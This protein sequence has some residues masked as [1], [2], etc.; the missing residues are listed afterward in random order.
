[1]SAANTNV[2]WFED[3]SRGDISLVGD[4][5]QFRRGEAGWRRGGKIIEQ[6]GAPAP[7][8]IETACPVV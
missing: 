4:A 2:I 8:Q 3:L 7:E 1:M 6:V 5:R